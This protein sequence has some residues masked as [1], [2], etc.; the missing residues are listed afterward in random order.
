[1]WEGGVKKLGQ[2]GDI[3][4]GTCAEEKVG[5]NLVCRQFTKHKDSA[6]L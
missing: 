6:W 3:T 4:Y 1:M 5:I 2:S